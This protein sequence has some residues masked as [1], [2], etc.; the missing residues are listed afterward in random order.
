MKTNIKTTQEIQMINIEELLN[1]GWVQFQDGDSVSPKN[2]DKY[3]ITEGVLNVNNQAGG[4][5]RAYGSSTLN[6]TGQ[7][8]GDCWAYG[9]S[10]LNATGQTGGRCVAF[11]SSTLN[12]I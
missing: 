1:N 2:G 3:F 6:A 5:C 4:D 11:E 12:K 10:T 7:I 8:D 9:S